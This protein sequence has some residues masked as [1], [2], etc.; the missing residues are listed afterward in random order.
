MQRQAA[1][2]VLRLNGRWLLPVI[3]LLGTAAADAR[4]LANLL[5]MSLEELMSL[6][7]AV[8]S[9]G[10]QHRVATSPVPIDVVSGDALR[11]T[12]EGELSRALQRLLPSFNY[13]RSAVADGT[14]HSRPSTLRGMGADQVLVLVNGK[15][16]HA[17]ALLHLN[18][19]IGRGST[20]TD[21][22]MIPLH[23]VERVEV[24]RDGAAAQYGSD[25]IAGILN[26]VLRS[27]GEESVSLT[28]G[29]TREGDGDLHQ[30]SVGGGRDWQDG[31]LVRIDGEVRWRGATNRSGLDRRQLYFDGDRRNSAPA[32]VT[33]SLGDAELDDLL[34]SASAATARRDG[35]QGYLNAT[36]GQREGVS[37]GFFRRPLDNRTVRA[38]YPDGFL[39]E[40]H[41]TIDDL[42]INAGLRSNRGEWSWDLN[43]GY[44]LNDF[45]FGVGNS[46]NTSF[47]AASPTEFDSGALRF[48]HHLLNLDGVGQLGGA[49]GAPLQLAW[50][51]ELRHENFMI[52]A[53]EPASWLH[54]GV[55]VL[56]GPDQGAI[57]AAGSQ[58]FPGFKPVNEVDVSRYN[59]S[60][61]LDLEYSP[62]PTLL[63]QGAVRMEHYS[64]FGSTV[65]GKL[66][67]AYSPVSSATLRG[68][69]SSGFRAPS[70]A[71]SHFTSTATVFIGDQ[72]V[73][74]GTFSVDHPLSRALGATDLK[75]ERSH[76]LSAGVHLQPTAELAVSAD[77]FANRISD[78]I[79]LSGDIYQNADLYGVGPSEALRSFG[80]LGA[81]YFSNAVDTRTHG[82]D[83]SLDYQWSLPWGRL[84]LALQYHR[85]RT[86]IDGEVRAPAILGASG[87]EIVLDRVERIQRIEQGHPA[88]SLQISAIQQLAEWRLTLRL[89]RY[90]SYR[91]VHYLDDPAY[92]QTIDPSWLT[93]L[94]LRWEPSGGFTV[95]FGAH[96][97][98]DRYPERSVGRANDP[99][100]G[101]IIPYA[102]NAPYGYNGAYYY[103]KVGYRF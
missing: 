70:L 6:N 15:R 82:L 1:A 65:N 30:L 92:D 3:T 26:I 61:Y 78:R 48:R 31:A 9:R 84:D 43:Y 87:G 52:D 63:T 85:N 51:A 81:R 41:S 39:P 79:V 16:R 7:V 100:V 25:A 42:A 44:G 11:L 60:A 17:G 94:D 35:R 102:P 8:G 59:L 73:E 53:G 32:H 24:L 66:A 18:A 40:I 57:T 69:L 36:L 96:N 55:D 74:I 103:L 46:L 2:R 13:P 14:D 76:H 20:S 71:Q 98:F 62:L 93:D 68:S 58:V 45:H 50:G 21:L 10:E 77:L 37:T 54:G 95:S 99:F 67:A 29:T 75:P 28:S 83:L 91:L 64:D 80:V 56:D 33:H 72:P 19:T 23:A 12:G 47:G 97:L 88:D 49:P 101:S 4:P 38:L 22:N 89:L 27:D 90:G 5:E 86:R 34:L